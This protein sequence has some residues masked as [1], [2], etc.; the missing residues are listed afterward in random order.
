MTKNKEFKLNPTAASLLGFLHERSMTGWDLV[1][2]A[3][4]RIGNFW[5]LTKSQ[6]YRELQALADQGLVDSGERGVRE[7]R[8]FAITPAGREAFSQWLQNDPTEETIRYPLL[9]SASFADYLPPEKL[10]EFIETHREQHQRRLE[11]YRAE[12]LKMQSPGDGGVGRELTFSFGIQYEEMVL[13][14]MEE[15]LERLKQ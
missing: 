10:I 5:N 6:V 9:L 1:E 13:K 7:K 11:Q 3:D 15:T 12:L 2:V 4:S 14:W 8:L